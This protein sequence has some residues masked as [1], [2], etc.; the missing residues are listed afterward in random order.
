MGHGAL[1]GDK[2]IGVGFHGHD[3]R[4]A[5]EQEVFSNSMP[6]TSVSLST[7]GARRCPPVPVLRRKGVRTRREIDAERYALK[8]LRGDF[9]SV[10]AN[11]DSNAA[12][13]AAWE[14]A[15]A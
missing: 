4:L 15:N 2:C 7:C 11:A 10:Q 9:S 1:A 6:C 13:R 12:G 14:A 3:P 5:G 8:A